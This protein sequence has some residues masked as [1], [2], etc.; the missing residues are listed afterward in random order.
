EAGKQGDGEAGEHGGMEIWPNPAGEQ[1]HV[2]LN[3]DD[4]RFNKDLTLVIYNIFGREVQ[5]I[6][7]PD[8]QEKI[9]VNVQG[10]SPGVYIAILKKSFNL[11]ESRKFV[12][13]R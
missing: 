11:V 12:V 4:G 9:L 1:I 10:F 13:A 6:K 8:G 7:I 3:M 5:K 2:R